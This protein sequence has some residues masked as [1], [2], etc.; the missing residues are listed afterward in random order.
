VVGVT[1]STTAGGARVVVLPSCTQVVGREL[2]FFDPGSTAAGSNIW[3]LTVSSQKINNG[4]VLTNIS[5]NN[6]CIKLISHTAGW[7]IATKFP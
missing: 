7:T 1:N 3:L 6:G 5:A 4:P 2:T